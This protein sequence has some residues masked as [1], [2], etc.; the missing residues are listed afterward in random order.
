MKFE[1]LFHIVLICFLVLTACRGN[2]EQNL[3]GKQVRFS[4]S[5]DSS[6]VALQGLPADVLEYLGSDTLAE[7][8]WQAFFGVYPEPE[9]PELKDIQRPVSGSYSVKDSII[10]FVPA[11]A[12]KK[13]S[14]YFA[15]FYSRSILAKPS[16][17]IMGE[18]GLSAQADVVEFVFKR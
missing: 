9:D 5:P 13:D 4:L 14:L 1:N 8:E 3:H 7:K 15:R 11:E 6:A 17:V 16:D 2:R 12:F 10:L 18:G